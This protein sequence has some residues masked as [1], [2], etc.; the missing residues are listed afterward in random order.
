MCFGVGEHRGS[1]PGP[2]AD[3]HSDFRRIALGTLDV[4]AEK[5]GFIICN[6]AKTPPGFK[7]CCRTTTRVEL[8]T[9]DRRFLL[10]V[11]RHLGGGDG[12]VHWV[13][14]LLTQTRAR[15]LINGFI[16][17]P[18][19]F[20]QGVRQGDP[21]SPP[22]YLF[23]ALALH[24]FL[25][26]RGH[27]LALPD[28]TLAPAQYADDTE[29]FFSQLAEADPILSSLSTFALA[30]GQRLNPSK[31][32]VVPLG[33]PPPDLPPV[34]AGVPVASRASALGFEFSSLGAQA[35]W[36]P[37]YNRVLER[38]SRIA[39]LPLSS[40]GRGFAASGYGLSRILYHLEF[41][42]PLGPVWE[43]R[44]AELERVTAKLVDRGLAPDDRQ[45][46]FAGLS[47]ELLTGS[48][49]LGG[50]AV[51]PLRAHLQA[52]HALWAIR[53]VTHVS[54]PC[55]ATSQSGLNQGESLIDSRDFSLESGI[56]LMLDILPVFFNN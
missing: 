19:L 17:N 26:R 23:I 4:T 25:L 55:H 24:F 47:P 41:C 43:Q 34:V 54:R 13:T 53:I 28:L 46:R 45:R 10:D 29:V 2:L 48:P 1:N 3:Y 32:A 15:A 51:L 7:I 42:P 8:P 39:R 14:L 56:F 49:S 6:H 33:V 16:S 37:L 30:S 21:L 44:L 35:E 11:I 52:R 27:T 38:Y 31:S 36:Q 22:L 20:E 50:F 40:F 5:H 18:H 12:L 9:I